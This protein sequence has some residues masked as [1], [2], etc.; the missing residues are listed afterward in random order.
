MIAAAVA[1]IAL[2]MIV[3][4]VVIAQEANFD[5]SYKTGRSFAY[6]DETITYTIVAINSG[7]PVTNVTLVDPVP[8]TT[9]YVLGS[10]AYRRT[11]TGSQPC[12]LP[13]LWVEDFGAGE[14]I[15]TT[16]AVQLTFGSM[17]WPLVN[18]ATLAWGEIQKDLTFT[19]TVSL[20][21]VCIMPIILRN[22]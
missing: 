1:G 17:N 13:D 2:T 12:S 18:K 3:V 14:R 9:I 8:N 21:H 22:H 20:R 11:G 5:L 16:F 7:G 4:G 10:C 15:T 19:T 6:T